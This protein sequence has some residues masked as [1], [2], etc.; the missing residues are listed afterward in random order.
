[1]AQEYEIRVNTGKV[2]VPV[3]D[4]DGEELGRITFN[5]ADAD[6]LR[7]YKATLEA[8][9]KI[10]IPSNPTEDEILAISDELKRQMDVLFAYPVSEGLFAKCNPLT[11]TD[12]GDFYI[13]T[14]INGIG[15]LLEQITKQRVAEK[16]AKIRKASAPYKEA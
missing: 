11:F 5:P 13:E 7:R 10:T 2:T 9:N 16:K 15:V 8:L 3:I 1:M 6:I 14:V 12:S 4:S